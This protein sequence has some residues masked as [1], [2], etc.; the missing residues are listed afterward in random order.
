MRAYRNK[1]TRI[2]EGEDKMKKLWNNSSRLYKVIAIVLTL[3]MVVT[4]LYIHFDKRYDAKAYSGNITVSKKF[5]PTDGTIP[6]DFQDVTGTADVNA[7][8]EFYYYIK[9]DNSDWTKISFIP[10]L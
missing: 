2:K 3:I 1:T 8:G 4:P 10:I 6:D 7:D 5:L 9:F